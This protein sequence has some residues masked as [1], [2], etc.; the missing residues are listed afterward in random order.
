MRSTRKWATSSRSTG[1][2]STASKADDR[3]RARLEIAATGAREDRQVRRRGIGAQGLGDDEAVDAGHAEIADD[4]VGHVLRR[5]EHAAEPARGPERVE[6]GRGERG[7]GDLQEVEI[8]IDDEDATPRLVR[9]GPAFME[10]L[11]L[12]LEGI[13]ATFEDRCRARC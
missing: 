1:F 3:S 4:R 11:G 12:E 9:R 5:E 6:A 8:V 13:E 2:V 10:G 7:L